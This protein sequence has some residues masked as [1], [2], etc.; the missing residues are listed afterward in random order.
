MT[1]TAE[2]PSLDLEQI[3]ETL[4]RYGVA[5]LLVGGSAARLYGASRLTRD[6]DCL[7]SRGAANLKCLGAA[8]R[9]LGARL[10]VEGMSDEDARSLPAP[11][12]PVSLGRLQIST[13]RTDAGDIDILVDIPGR[14][15]HGLGFEDLI[16]RAKETTVGHAK[17]LVADLGDIIAS[18]EWANRPK[19][20]EALSE[21]RRLAADSNGA[22]QGPPSS[23]RP[24]PPA[25]PPPEDGRRT[26]PPL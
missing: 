8:M 26:R 13:W 9:E 5:Y 7:V 17:I 25:A 21:L 18:K 6:V 12:D 19:D 24:Y 22:G 23:D 10:R 16:E 14:D 20:Q 1:G 11:L 2:P 4:D 15:G 3:V